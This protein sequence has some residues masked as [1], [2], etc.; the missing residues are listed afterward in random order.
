M[1]SV[2]E[3]LVLGAGSIGRRHA[4]NLVAAGARVV[5][6]DPDADRARTVEG[7]EAVPFRPEDLGRFDGVVV[8]SPTADHARDARW[9][10][11]SDC[12]V[13]VE[14]PLAT[15]VSE[16]GDLEADGR[17][18]VGY[19]LRL[20]DPVRKTVTRVHRG[21]VGRPLLVRAWFGWYLPYWRPAVDY[22]TTYSARSDQGGGILLDASHELDLLVW[23]L[24]DLP[25]DIS[26]AVVARIGNLEIDTEDTVAALLRHQTGALVE[27]SLDYL[28]RS[29][30]R[31]LEIVGEEATLRLDWSR[32]VLEREDNEGIRTESV[33]LTVDRSYEEE[34][35]RFLAFVRDGTPPPVDARTGAASIRLADAIRKAAR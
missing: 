33:E 1:S 26:G 21:D 24:G 7:A 15:S 30:R 2:P 32:R 27:L 18:M 11:A 25:F 35:H 4:R 13:L 23:M 22:R 10:L 9:A 20:H 19:N 16:L 29:Y 6:T 8:A 3:I 12:R 5:V 17:V 28:S 14:K 31:G 34:A